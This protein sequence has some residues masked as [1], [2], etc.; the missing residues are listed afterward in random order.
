MADLLP[1]EQW[2]PPEWLA[3]EPMPAEI[4]M[5]PLN[6]NAD[7]VQEQA[8]PTPVASAE[9]DM[10]PLDLRPQ[11]PQQAALPPSVEVLETAPGELTAQP[12]PDGWDAFV[13]G[14]SQEEPPP[15]AF[16]G[17]PEPQP[18]PEPAFQAA[19]EQPQPL[20]EQ[21]AE[22]PDW[23]EQEEADRNVAEMSDEEYVNYSVE[24]ER[25]AAEAARAEREA[26]E[27]ENQRR[28]E[29]NQQADHAA[30]ETYRRQLGDIKT[31]LQQLSEQGIDNDHWWS[32]RSTG[33]KAALYGSAI[34]NGFLNPGG[35][36]GAIEMVQGEIDR[37]IQTQVANLNAARGNLAEQ[38]GLVAELYRASGDEY[39]AAETARLAMYGAAIKKI[40][41]DAQNFDPRG[42]AA[43]K[44]R[45]AIA[46]LRGR[47]AAAAQKFEA[48]QWKRTQEATRLQLDVNKDAREQGEYKK[49]MAGGG[50]ARV[51]APEYYGQLYGK[52]PPIPM[53]EKQ[54]QSWLSTTG[55]VRSLSGNDVESQ[56][57]AAALDKAKLEADQAQRGDVILDDEGQPLGRPVDV[58][59]RQGTDEKIE[60]YGNLRS[61]LSR[62]MDYIAK[63]PTE[64][65]LIGRWKSENKAAVDQLRKQVATTYAKIVDPVGAVS[66]KTIESAM[67]MLPDVEGWTEKKHPTVVYQQLTTTADDKMER[68]AKRAI[69]GYQ[70]GRL[71][72]KWQSVDRQVLAP[73]VQPAEQEGQ[74]SLIERNL[75]LGAALFNTPGSAL[76]PEMKQQLRELEA[77]D[78]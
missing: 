48:E 26:V 39:Q 12:I 30:R 11:E 41:T 49:K 43:M 73:P 15:P 71:T 19:P 28:M 37:D 55:K 31:H 44:A 40:E 6:V 78:D 36:N 70:P 3:P 76:T 38:T 25:K 8:L 54:Y 22:L 61:E 33:Q 66:D 74:P 34:I 21:P 5:D 24:R 18:A 75:D 63:K 42:A 14:M 1:I 65:K 45:E 46:D 20:G 13:N 35:R 17:Q 2:P 62:L 9:M 68:H 32:T 47:E 69:E 64:Q 72:S 10:T 23:L 50:P 60:A 67:D 4:A 27:M 16:M 58:K 52:A 56:A 59:Q 53:S 51:F 77:E 7:A 29:A 57:K